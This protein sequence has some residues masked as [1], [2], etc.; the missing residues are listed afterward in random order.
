MIYAYAKEYFSPDIL[1][2]SYSVQ[3]IIDYPWDSFMTLAGTKKPS[4]Q[5]GEVWDGEWKRDPIHYSPQFSELIFLHYILSPTP[6]STLLKWKRKL[7]IVTLIPSLSDHLAILTWFVPFSLPH[8][9]IVSSEKN[10]WQL[11]NLKMCIHQTKLSVNTLFV[12]NKPSVLVLF[13]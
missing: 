4:H 8:G 11:Q 6:Q 10:D 13:D 2:S 12:L 3:E 5:I 1:S 9:G 7:V